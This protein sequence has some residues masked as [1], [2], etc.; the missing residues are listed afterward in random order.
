MIGYI[1]SIIYQVCIPLI[2]LPA[3]SCAIISI[4]QSSSISIVQSTIVLLICV[5]IK[6]L[7]N[8][9]VQ[10]HIAISHVVSIISSSILIVVFVIPVFD[11]NVGAVIS[12]IGG[13]SSITKLILFCHIQFVTTSLASICTVPL[14]IIP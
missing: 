2:L 10:D 3:L 11:N 12:I 5:H 1:V 4:S 6:L 8:A 7:Y 9:V 13:T 14:C